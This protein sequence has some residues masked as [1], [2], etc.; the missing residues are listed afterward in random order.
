MISRRDGDVRGAGKEQLS[1]AIL[2]KLFKTM[3]GL[4]GETILG[5]QDN[6]ENGDLRFPTGATIEC[7]GQPIDPN[8]YQQNFVEVFEVTNNPQ[9]DEGFK[10][11]G[12]VLRITP[13]RLA[14]IPV[15]FGSTKDLLGR[16][17]RVSLSVLSMHH[18]SYT[19][20]VNYEDAGRFIYLYEQDEIVNLVREAALKGLRRGAGNSNEDTFSVFVPIAKMRWGRL[21]SDWVYEGVG[22]EVGKLEVLKSLLAG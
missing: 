9:H 14:K 10:R 12:D 5:A 19:A 15:T 22:S 8:R 4:S 16:Q 17:T 21:G 7:K 13:D 1:S 11:L 6:Y 18:A 2:Q 20:Y 3:I